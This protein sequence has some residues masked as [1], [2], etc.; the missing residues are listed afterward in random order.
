[1]TISSQNQMLSLAAVENWLHSFKIFR[2]FGSCF[3]NRMKCQ[4]YAHT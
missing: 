4:F 1:M 2:Q 3:E